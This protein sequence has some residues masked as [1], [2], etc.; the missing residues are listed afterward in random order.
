MTDKLDTEP[1]Q[2]HEKA[3]DKG[4]PVSPEKGTF[5]RLG[6]MLGRLISVGLTSGGNALDRGIRWIEQWLVSTKK[7]RY[8]LAVTRILLGFVGLGLLFTNFRT[9]L[10]SF[11]SGSAWNGEAAEP[12]SDFP[13]IWIFSLFHKL[14]LHDVW[15]TLA[16]LGLAVLGVLVLLGW[17]T[18]LILPIFFVMWVS[19][20]EVNDTLG[21]QGD[22]M[23]RITLL[24]LLFADTAS[25]WSLDAKRRKAA[26]KARGPWW[27][28]A[29]Q[30][31]SYVPSWISNTAHNLAL[32]IVATHVSMVYAS[33]ALYKAGGAPWQHGYAIYNPLQ[34]QR[35]GTWPELSELFTTWAPMVV[36]ISWTSVILQ[37]S[38]P[39]MLFS[40]PTRIIA[41]IGIG[42]FHIG[43]GVLM[44][45]PWFSLAMIAIDAIFVRDRTWQTLSRTIK[46]AWR[47][48]DSAALPGEQETTSA[49]PAGVLAG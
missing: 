40:R 7:A 37:M 19:F 34:T 20:I 26:A 49:S 3:V 4:A 47:A 11:G 25:V 45:L 18:K 32:V 2:E 1:D 16:I 38:F 17:R 27:K 24:T 9:R 23:Y 13:K 14:A 10:Y 43:I 15:F 41:L 48:T 46:S 12:I 33:G 6:L 36:A 22:N 39:M 21:D 35:F 31:A 5:P 29:W 44:G 8:G 28:R 42:G 30:G